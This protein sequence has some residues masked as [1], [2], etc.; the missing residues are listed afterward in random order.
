MDML[1][2]ITAAAA[3]WMFGAIW[4]G[5]VG[6]GWMQAAG[7]TD[8]TINRRNYT[9]FV[10][11]FIAAL[12]VAG[13]IRH[14]MASSGVTGLMDGAVTGIG[15]GLFIASPWVVTNYLFA[16]RP[17]MLAVYDCGYATGGSAAM[18]AVLGVVT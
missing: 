4:Y 7:L 10:G 12:L 17:A 18:G 6:A 9:A 2:V 15:L 16:Q 8:R 5:I 1:G 13:M 11:S 3:G 14:L